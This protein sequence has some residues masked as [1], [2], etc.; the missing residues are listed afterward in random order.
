MRNWPFFAVCPP[1]TVSLAC[2]AG[3]PPPAPLLLFVVLLVAELV[4]LVELVPPVLALAELVLLVTAVPPEPPSPCNS[5]SPSTASHPP[6]AATRPD[7]PTPTTIVLARN[8]SSDQ[9]LPLTSKPPPLAPTT[10]VTFTGLSTTS[11]M[12]P[13]SSTPPA[14]SPA[15][16]AFAAVL[17]FASGPDAHPPLDVAVRAALVRDRERPCDDPLEDARDAQLASQHDARGIPRPARAP[18][19]H[20]RRPA[21]GG[22]ATGAVTGTTALPSTTAMGGS[23]RLP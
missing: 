5:L 1:T 21:G 20:R 4:L 15:S 2:T 12:P 14:M 10:G 16:Q 7:S 6:S 13:A 19:P 23:A 18:A 22:G 11:T 8:P 17:A 9:K 3:P